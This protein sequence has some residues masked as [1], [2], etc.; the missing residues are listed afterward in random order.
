MNNFTV[1]FDEQCHKINH[2]IKQR[3]HMPISGLKLSV[4]YIKD[5]YKRFVNTSLCIYSIYSIYIEIN[6]FEKILPYYPWKHSSPSLES[7][8]FELLQ[9][10]SEKIKKFIWIFAKLWVNLEKLFFNFAK[11]YPNFVIKYTL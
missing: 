3:T 7:V 8:E 2:I 10:L 1:L 4:I 6:L 5:L 11:M 9:S